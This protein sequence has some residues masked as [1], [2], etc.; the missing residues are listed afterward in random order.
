MEARTM[1]KSIVALIPVN[2]V[3]YNPSTHQFNQTLLN[4][5]KAH[6]IRE[7]YL[8]CDFAECLEHDLKTI[9]S[10]HGMAVDQIVKRCQEEHF[11]VRG[12][13][14]SIDLDPKAAPGEGYAVMYLPLLEEAG[15][16]RSPTPPNYDALLSSF[17][18]SD[19]DLSIGAEESFTTKMG[20]IYSKLLKEQHHAFSAILYMDCDEKNL[21]GALS[22]DVTFAN[23]Q[24]QPELLKIVTLE[25]FQ[26]EE[27][28]D[29]VT[30]ELAIKECTSKSTLIAADHRLLQ[31]DQF[32]FLMQQMAS[33][34]PAIKYLSSSEFP[35]QTLRA[36]IEAIQ[37]NTAL[38][39]Y[40]QVLRFEKCVQLSFRN[41]VSRFTKPSYSNFFTQP[42]S[43]LQLL[44][45]YPDHYHAE[46]CLGLLL[47][48]FYR[49]R[50]RL[51]EEFP[52]LR[53][54]KIP[55]SPCYHLVKRLPL[56][57]PMLDAVTE[58][59]GREETKI[60]PKMA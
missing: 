19:Y 15:E 13:L 33:I 51:D 46:R 38:S 25:P 34:N 36:E 53:E 59:T 4:V 52:W 56:M 37:R 28:F 50:H 20:L 31:R 42:K 48:Q 43:M 40:A 45:E 17:I 57:V 16:K 54:I 23:K 55:K 47:L 58:S 1:S 21:L 30:L 27:N 29:T 7:I 9:E 24:K 41:I 26:S 3:L 32:Y 12:V 22:S 5:L 60:A 44:N 49:R 6:G 39:P 35:L 8:F 18:A 10:N 11:I 2:G 14:S